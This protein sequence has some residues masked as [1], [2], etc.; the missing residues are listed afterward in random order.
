MSISS[1]YASLKHYDYWKKVTMEEKIDE[2]CEFLLHW[3]QRD[4]ARDIKKAIYLYGMP[5]NTYKTWLDRSEKLSEFIQEIRSVIGF[6][7]CEMAETREN[8][9]IHRRLPQY[10]EDFAKAVNDEQNRRLEIVDRKAKIV[11]DELKKIAF[12]LPQIPK[13]DAVDEAIKRSEDNQSE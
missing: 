3:A 7:L 10:H 8:T 2:L 11:A 1:P 12:A 4:D 6:R 5:Y 9:S 13:T